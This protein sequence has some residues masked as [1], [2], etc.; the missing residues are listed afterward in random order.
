MASLSFSR[1]RAKQFTPAS[2]RV[3]FLDFFNITLVICNN[4][5]ISP[6]FFL[7]VNF[8]TVRLKMKVGV[9]RLCRKFQ[10]CDDLGVFALICFNKLCCNVLM[11]IFKLKFRT[12]TS[13]DF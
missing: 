13:C 11:G 1:Q 3:L 6:N 10:T 2:T 12:I 4:N 8:N 9:L 7:S 5:A